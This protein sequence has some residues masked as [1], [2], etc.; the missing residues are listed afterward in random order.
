L[1]KGGIGRIKFSDRKGTT[2]P[3]EGTQEKDPLGTS[4]EPCT[5][6]TPIDRKPIVP[7]PRIIGNTNKQTPPKTTDKR[8]NKHIRH[9]PIRV[10]SPGPIPT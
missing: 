4:C 7:H 10:K 1:F 2:I 3:S 8:I 9:Q 6:S 5:T